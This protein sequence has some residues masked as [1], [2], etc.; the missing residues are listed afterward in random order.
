MQDHELLFFHESAVVAQERYKVLAKQKG[1]SEKLQ[2]QRSVQR[3][4]EEGAPCISS[5][6]ELVTSLFIK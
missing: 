6:K 1:I 4:I 5:V 3:Y 2:Y